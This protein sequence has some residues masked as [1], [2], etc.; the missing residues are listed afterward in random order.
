MDAMGKYAVRGAISRRIAREG[1][2]GKDRRHRGF[3]AGLVVH[4]VRVK[5]PMPRSSRRSCR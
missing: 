1:Q 4:P 3:R 2:R 5:E